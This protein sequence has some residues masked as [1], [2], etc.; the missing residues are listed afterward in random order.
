MESTK[1]GFAIPRYPP[2]F[3]FGH[4]QQT[5]RRDSDSAAYRR[6]K[7]YLRAI[8]PNFST[9]ALRGLLTFSQIYDTFQIYQKW[10][11][12]TVSSQPKR[13][14]KQVGGVFTPLAP[15]RE[16]FLAL[17]VIQILSNPAN[18]YGRKAVRRHH[19][20]DQVGPRGPAPPVPVRL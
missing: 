7:A 9:F 6:E 14:F 5:L 17:L 16:F 15:L 19:V 8:F 1:T 12:D 4:P 18:R 2:N 13:A 3:H 10:R 20:P 11:A